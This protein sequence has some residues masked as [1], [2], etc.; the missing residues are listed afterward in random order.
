MDFLY[1]LITE[2]V[3]FFFLDEGYYVQSAGHCNRIGRA[4]K[5]GFTSIMPS[6]PP[7]LHLL[8]DGWSLCREPN[9]PAALHLLAILAYLPK[10]VQAHML[11]PETPPP[12][13][14]KG[15]QTHVAPTPLASCLQW[16]QR[17][18]PQWR[19]KL[20]AHLLHLTTETASLLN[21]GHTVI[22]PTQAG[23]RPQPERASRGGLFSRVRV[24]LAAGGTARAQAVFWPEDLPRPA[25]DVIPLPP[26]VHPDFIPDACDPLQI[27]G[28]DL[29][30][31][32]VLYHG[33]GDAISLRRALEAWTWA[34]GPV[35]QD[36]PLVL[37][38]LGAEAQGIVERLAQE[39]NLRDTLVPLPVIPPGWV[40]PL[41]R[42]AQALFHPAS[43]SAWGGAIRHALAC[44]KPV[45]AAE[46][47]WASAIVG[48]A[49]ILVEPGDTRR[50]GA[51]VIGVIVKEE[52]SAQ[53][54][55][56]AIARSAGW[57]DVKWGE[58]LETAY[59]R[60]LNPWV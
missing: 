8:Y 11:C 30:E 54:R 4:V 34:A 60:V 53:L 38:G 13:L 26:I 40:A 27:P 21:G 51:G 12:W 16:E 15:V 56:A 49:A 32:Y 22:S 6:M 43:V 25:R 19:E 36:Y 47:A 29:P 37:L 18:L 41:Y 58:K 42:R 2:Q 14:P 20:E 39:L 46:T 7:P 28:V 23:E 55:E 33:P 9:S 35:G 24:A 1:L 44:G 57:T 3:R 45:V 10:H 50:L 17:T 59:T 52:L 5:T 48:P 31:T